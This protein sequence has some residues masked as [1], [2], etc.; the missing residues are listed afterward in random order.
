MTD[1]VP[2]TTAEYA[3]GAPATSSHFERWFRNPVAITEGAPGAPRNQDGSLSGNITDY[4]RDWVLNRLRPQDA[5]IR[6]SQTA[7]NAVGQVVFAARPANTDPGEVVTGAGL[8]ASD[9]QGNV[10]TSQPLPG[11]WRCQ[12]RIRSNGEY[13]AT[14]FIRVS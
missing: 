2:F 3:V 1:W 5:S 6:Y 14:N 9:N 11:M 12:G 8:F 10:N 7:W 13:V 4:G